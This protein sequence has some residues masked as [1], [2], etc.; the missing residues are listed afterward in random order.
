MLVIIP[1]VLICL[2][3]WYVRSN[4]VLEGMDGKKIPRV[5]FL[6]FIVLGLIP[7]LNIIA[8]IGMIVAFVC[9]IG[10]ERIE[11]KD[12]RLNRFFGD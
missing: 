4:W 7:I 9:G 11:P 8:G 10:S 5:I 12:T 6:I 3:S 2:F 1:F